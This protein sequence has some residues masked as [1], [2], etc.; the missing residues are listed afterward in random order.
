MGGSTHTHIIQFTD[1]E[2][3]GDS[4]GSDGSDHN[5][6]N[7]SSSG[8]EYAEE[9]EEDEYEEDEEEQK[10]HYRNRRY[11]YENEDDGD[12]T[13]DDDDD[14]G[15]Y[16]ADEFVLKM[17]EHLSNSRERLSTAKAEYLKSFLQLLKDNDG[18]TGT[19]GIS[20]QSQS[21]HHTP[22]HTQG[23]SG[24]IGEINE[25]CEIGGYGTGGGGGGETSGGVDGS[26]AVVGEREQAGDHQGDGEIEE[27]EVGDQQNQHCQHQITVSFKFGSGS[28]RTRTP[29]SSVRL[30]IHENVSDLQRM[31]AHEIGNIDYRRLQLLFDDGNGDG[32]RGGGVNLSLHPQ[33][34]LDRAGFQ[35]QS[36]NHL[37]V[38]LQKIANVSGKA[39]VLDLRE[40]QPQQ[41]P[42]HRRLVSPTV[43]PPAG[44]RHRRNVSRRPKIVD[45]DF[46]FKHRERKQTDVEIESQTESFVCSC[47]S[48]CCVSLFDTNNNNN[49]NNNDST[50]TNTNHYERSRSGSK[51]T[52]TNG[53]RH[54][55]GYEK[56]EINGFAI[57]LCS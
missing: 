46:T 22:T 49:N 4:D 26:G 48:L 31:I 39:L 41:R 1:S 17:N 35:L 43:P 13:D 10:Y 38:K 8:C 14:D 54:G 57:E 44:A 6:N 20:A 51:Q 24:E 45:T 12:D 50:I 33:M 37:I 42:Q 11:E 40:Q 29:Y 47:V 9:E 28:S 36:V 19:G 55:H 3:S 32:S 27:K 15:S 2:S 7:N 25:I 18:G 16:S 5:N 34:S 52:L 30:G 56:Q 23:E 21:H 53:H